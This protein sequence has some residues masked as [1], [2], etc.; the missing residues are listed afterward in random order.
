MRDDRVGSNGTSC[1]RTGTVV[2]AFRRHSHFQRTW[3]STIS[4]SLPVAAA[5]LVDISV[6]AL[7]AEGRRIRVVDVKPMDEWYQRFDDV[8][9]VVADLQRREACIAACD[10]AAEVYQLAC[11]MGGMGF[12]EHNKA[13]CMLSVLI[14]THMLEAARD[15]GVRRFFYSSSACVYN[16]DKQTRPDLVA[17]REEDAYPGDARGW[18]RLGEAVLGAHVPALPRGLRSRDA[19]GA[20]S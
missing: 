13:L 8:E 20:L 10:G 14:N 2:G 19:R 12:I 16:A 3:H 5:S 11:D 17:L 6:A 7:R 18:L 15:A 1:G 9:N 4:S